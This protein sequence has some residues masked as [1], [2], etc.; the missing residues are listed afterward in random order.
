ME[1][2]GGEWRLMEANG[3]E[4]RLT[5]SITVSLPH[6]H[7][8]SFRQVSLSELGQTISKGHEERSPAAMPMACGRR[9]RVRARSLARWLVC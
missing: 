9:R 7:S 3:G 1:A 4:W 6:Q 8:I 2:N 5:E